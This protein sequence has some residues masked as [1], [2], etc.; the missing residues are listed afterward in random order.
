MTLA[1]LLGAAAA[2]PL[3]LTVEIVGVEEPLERA[4][5]ASLGI[6]HAQNDPSLTPESIER[7]H[8]RAPDEIRSALQ[9]FGYYTPG[10]SAELIKGDR[11]WTARYR[12]RPGR[13]VVIGDVE[14]TISGEGSGNGRLQK[15][16]RDFPLKEGER[17][18][19]E[20][21]EAAKQDLL[22]AAL[23][24][25]YLEAALTTHEV[26]VYPEAH[27]AV[28]M[29]HLATGPLYR[30]GEVAFEQEA[31]RPEFLAR[32]LTFGKG[33]PY[34]AAELL[35]LQNAL[36]DSD[37]FSA[38][39]VTPRIEEAEDRQV[40]ITVK[41]T[42][43]KRQRYTV[44][45]GYGTDTGFRG[46]LEWENRR[47][48]R[49]GH[50]FLS[51]LNVSEIEQSLTA[52]YIIPMRYPR[53]DR[54]EF[55]AGTSH[56]DTR[57]SRS[58]TALLGASYTRKRGAWQIS[59][60][61]TAL[62]EDF[63]V[64]DASGSSVLLL[65]G[66]VGSRVRS[67]DPVYPTSGSRI[68]LEVKGAHTALLSDVSFAQFRAQVKQVA[69][70]WPTG[71]LLARADL[72][73]SLISAFDELPASQ[74]FFAGGDRSVRGYAYNS[75]GPKRDGEVIGGKHLLVG[76]IEYEQ[77]LSRRWSAAVFYDVGN[78]LSR[79]SDPLKQGTG[80]G[81]RWRSPV[82]LVRLDFA[83]ALNPEP[84]RSHWRLHFS[85]GPDL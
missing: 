53:T 15:L 64:A 47:V 49:R 7:L 3:P 34:R 57:T 33:S 13:A 58:E 24:Q 29:L 11:R 2:A 74:R 28:V 75:L 85:A 37:Y 48:N 18:Q 50:R 14:V 42:P 22:E 81:L 20:R 72:G 36:Q 32:F 70:P 10:I 76:S 63:T 46:V 61:T 16:R 62:Y 39:E 59:Y 69:T 84:G 77:S 40:P 4:L 73:A 31:F 5:R 65:P 71:R 80:L 82:G 35:E 25:G 9:P 60:Y 27:T 38:V 23:G 79:F 30:F 55:S 44:G 19:H 67:N 17:L 83:W 51:E 12:V 68:I 26:R 6:Q 66:I 21:Y 43:K 1:G 45:V 41:L 78:A 56:E 52:R 54:L 8:E